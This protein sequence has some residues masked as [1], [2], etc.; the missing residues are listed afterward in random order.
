MNLQKYIDELEHVPLRFSN[1]SFWRSVRKFRELV[2]SALTEINANIGE[3]SETY[4]DITS[5]CGTLS[6]SWLGLRYYGSSPL[7]LEVVRLNTIGNQLVV[8][9]GELPDDFYKEKEL[10][11]T[12]RITA[13]NGTYYDIF[14]V[15]QLHSI[16]S[17]IGNVFIVETYP[18]TVV[19][20]ALPSGS[21]PSLQSVQF[22][23]Y[24][25]RG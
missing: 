9:K 16:V 6:D 14:L 7:M 17:N 24:K 11:V 2:T 4:W 5:H 10:R 18:R 19:D 1:L 8:P 23:Y 15:Y 3:L 22:V 13:S 21:I 20:G 25:K 12:I